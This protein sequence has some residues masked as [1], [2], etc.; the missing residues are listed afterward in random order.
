VLTTSA[1]WGL[2][3]A[4]DLLREVHDRPLSIEEVAREAAVSRFHF[5]RQ[6]AA[7]FGE[8]PHQFRIR[9]RAPRR[10]A[11]RASGSR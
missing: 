9:A 2:C 1:L 7:V 6:F 11:G 10:R 8:S 3:H 4:R 5:I